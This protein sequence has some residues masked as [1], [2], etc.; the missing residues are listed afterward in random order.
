TGAAF[1]TAV[2]FDDAGLIIGAAGA[3]GSG[4]R[5]AEAADLYQPGTLLSVSSTTTYATAPPFN[6][7]IL[8]GTF[9]DPRLLDT[10][11]ASIDSGDG[12]PP[13]IVNLPA[14]AYAFS[15]PHD[16]TD[17]SVARYSIGVTLTDNYGGTAL[18]QTVVA[19]SDPPP[20]FAPP[21]LVLSSSSIHENDTV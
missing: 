4:V 21:G 3:D 16:Y 7:V 18:A 8:S 10:H 6:S 9:R 15:V 12:S 17:D 19:I 1:G 11:T 14:G 20:A 13:T 2:G 5:G